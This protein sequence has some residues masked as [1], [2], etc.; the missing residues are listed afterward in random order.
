MFDRTIE[1]DPRP[2]AP[3][4]RA[5][6]RMRDGHRR[7]HAASRDRGSISF[8][9]RSERALADVGIYGAVSV[10]DLAETHFGGHPYT[11]R[12]AVNAW[13]REGLVKE[14]TATDIEGR[15]VRWRAEHEKTGYEHVTPLTAEAVAALGEAR[16]M[17][18]GTESGPVLSSPR[19]AMSCIS[20]V[21]AHNWWRKAQTLAGLEPKPGRGWHSLRRKF[22]SDLMDLPL[23]VLCELGGWDDGKTRPPPPPSVRTSPSISMARR[24]SG[25]LWGRWAF[26]RS[27]GMVH[28]V[29]RVWY[30]A[31][32][33]VAVRLAGSLALSAWRV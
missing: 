4:S 17:S 29:I 26:M 24:D 27:P 28:A 1:P 20:R 30:Y 8:R 5:T 7:E 33:A 18:Q 9:D 14:I 12:R 25:T 22:A 32:P 10:R 3:H 13:I 11:T 23:K 31:A 21:C 15:E 2:A 6:Y 19:D 16:R